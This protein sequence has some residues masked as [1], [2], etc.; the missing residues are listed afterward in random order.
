MVGQ[1][2]RGVVVEAKGGSAIIKSAQGGDYTY[3]GRRL[4]QGQKVAFN[5]LQGQSRPGTTII[6]LEVL[7]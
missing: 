5:L 4:K 7:G 3:H 6:N 1:K 2:I